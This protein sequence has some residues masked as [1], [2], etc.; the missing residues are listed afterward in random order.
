[1]VLKAFKP[2]DWNEFRIR[3]EGPRIQIWLNG[4]QTVD[5]TEKDDKI[6]RSGVIGLQVHAGKPA[7]AW[8]KD[9]RIKTFS[10]DRPASVNSKTAQGKTRGG[11]GEKGRAGEGEIGRRG[12]PSRVSG[13]LVSSP[14]R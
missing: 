4:Q 8:Y 7:E 12:E 9:V 10:G 2:N 3:C 5:Y 1:M 13:R 11:E 14:G 6:D